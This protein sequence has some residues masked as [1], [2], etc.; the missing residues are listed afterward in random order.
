MT[1][2]SFSLVSCFDLR[3]MLA[4]TYIQPDRL[5]ASLPSEG[6]SG[7]NHTEQSFTSINA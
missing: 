4:H 7:T 2:S 1:S 5:A 3:L 6:S